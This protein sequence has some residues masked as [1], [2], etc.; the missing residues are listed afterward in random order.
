MG[1]KF[2]LKDK[3]RKSFFT[4]FAINSR[5]IKTSTQFRILLFANYCCIQLQSFSR[6][7]KFQEKMVTS[8]HF[9]VKSCL[10]ANLSLEISACCSIGLELAAPTK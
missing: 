2:V 10:F 7:S 1:R 5:H 8:E 4:V 6:K 9:F 3:L